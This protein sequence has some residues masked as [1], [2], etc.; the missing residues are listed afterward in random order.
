[1]HGPDPT[2]RKRER[3]HVKNKNNNNNKRA[4]RFVAGG[5]LSRL[6]A[7]LERRGRLLRSGQGWGQVGWLRNILD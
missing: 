1:M 4:F 3:T 6:G 7:V 2:R 5:E